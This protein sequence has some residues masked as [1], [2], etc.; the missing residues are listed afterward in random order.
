MVALA[1]KAVFRCED[2]ADRDLGAL[3]ATSLA[4][5]ARE[6]DGGMALYWLS[7]LGTNG[8]SDASWAGMRGHVTAAVSVESDR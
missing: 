4:N 2:D 8:Q 3:R 6:Y 5:E 1:L 7:G